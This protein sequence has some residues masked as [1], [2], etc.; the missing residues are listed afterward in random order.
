MYKEIKG[1]LLDLFDQ[2]E[3]EIIGHGCNCKCIM[4]AGIAKQ[5]K[6]RYPE[7]YFSDR[8]SILISVEK[9]GN[10]SSNEEE[11]IFNLYSQYEPGKNL[12]YEALTLALRKINMCY[13]GLHIG[14]PQIGCGIA[15]GDW[16]RVKSI[17]QQELKDMDVTIVI[18]E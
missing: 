7:A 11:T 5:I 15:G 9:L 13:K 2:G 16:N 8:N 3:F 17:I 10:F 18:Y 4:G 14:L 12:D 6:E 1:N